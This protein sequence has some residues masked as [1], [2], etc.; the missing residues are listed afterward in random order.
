MLDH[1]VYGNV[2]RISPE[3]PVPVLHK[4]SESFFL[5]GAGNVF[6]NVFSLGAHADLLTLVGQDSE[7]DKMKEMISEKSGSS[8][9]VF[10]SSGRISTIK[11]RFIGNHFQLL[12]VDSETTEGISDQV[13]N[14]IFESI[15]EAISNYDCVIIQDYNKGLLTPTLITSIISLCKKHNKKII[16]D[17][18]KENI[19]KYAGATCLKPNFSEFSQMTGTNYKP[20]DLLSLEKTAKELIEKMGLDFMLITLSEHGMFHCNKERAFRRE[21]F[22]VSIADVSG[23]GDTVS[24]MLA[25]CVASEIPIVLTVDLCNMAASI[26]CSHSG[27]VSVKLDEVLFRFGW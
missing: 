13:S 19:E 10:T 7:G 2:S 18:K 9:F 25:L 11:T 21:A 3:A 27:A 8:N 16:V 6:S 20:T 14:L 24:A 1:Y 23:A 12:R 4:S 5:G 17:P 15:E 26:A 22:P